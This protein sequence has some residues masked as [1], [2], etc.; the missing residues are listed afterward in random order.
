VN[1][2]KERNYFVEHNQFCRGSDV[3]LHC[4]VLV[5]GRMIF[6]VHLIFDTVLKIRVVTDC[7]EISLEKKGKEK[8]K[9]DKPNEAEL[10]FY[11]TQTRFRFAVERFKHRNILLKNGTEKTNQ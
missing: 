8:P 2:K 1:D 6:F 4:Q 11:R 5:V 9:V 10:R 3:Q 7:R